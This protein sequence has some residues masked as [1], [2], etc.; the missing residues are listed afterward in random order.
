MGLDDSQFKEYKPADH[1][2]FNPPKQ[3]KFKFAKPGK[4]RIAASHGD[5]YCGNMKHIAMMSDILVKPLVL[6]PPVALSP[7]AA[8]PKPVT[9]AKPK[10][11]PCAKKNGQQID[12][13]CVA[14]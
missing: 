10:V 13:T 7:P 1:A 2:V 3:F 8:T 14:E 11:K 6:L 9:P 5:M 4:Y 12:P